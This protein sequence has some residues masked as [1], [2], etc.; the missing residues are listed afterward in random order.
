M[1]SDQA[2]L[3]KGVH[4]F[5]YKVE[6][7]KFDTTGEL[8]EVPDIFVEVYDYSTINQKSRMSYIRLKVGCTC[9]FLLR[10]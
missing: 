10:C 5:L 1:K 3:A 2:K 6:D 9:F 4:S 8:S 7:V